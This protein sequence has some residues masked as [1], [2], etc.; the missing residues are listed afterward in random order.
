MVSAPLIV[1]LF[2]RTFVAASLG[3]ALRKSWPL[4]LGLVSSWVLLLLLNLNSPHSDAAGFHLGVSLLAWW[5]TQAKIFLLYLKLTVWP[6]PLVI[7]YEL[8]YVDSFAAAWPYLLAVGVLGL[9]T[10]ILLWRNHPI[11]FLGVCVFVILSP[12]SIVPIVTEMAAERRMYLPLAALITLAVAGGY[13]LVR[14]ALRRGNRDRL[15]AYNDNSPLVAIGVA[16]TL[17]VIAFSLISFERL[18]VYEDPMKLWLQVV[19]L[20]PENH[21]AHQNVGAE[22]VQADRAQEAIPW[23]R[24]AIELNPKAT[25]AHYNLGLLLL[26][27]NRFDAAI[28]EFQEAV[29]QRPDLAEF[30]NN[31]GVALFTAGRIEEAIPLFRKTIELKPSMWSAH[32]N[33]GRALARSGQWHEAIANYEQALQINSEAL[34]VYSHLADAY[35]HAKVPAKAIAVAEKALAVAR[36]SGEYELAEKISLQVTK[37]RE[38]LSK[39]EA[40]ET[41]AAATPPSSN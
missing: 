8:P 22:L 19:K 16:A 13:S 25:Q 26:R 23:Y 2:E 33:L 4:Y 38:I 32:D 6:W 39:A 9:A 37:Y 17:I 35:A 10:L 28:A 34:D 40:E 21:L 27:A 7:H 20:Q 24:K 14:A 41:S 36:S 3:N 15:T 5:F 29:K 30:H 11:G 1:L 12:T 31:L 18:V